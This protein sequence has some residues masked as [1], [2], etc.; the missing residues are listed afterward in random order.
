MKVI[1]VREKMLQA[2]QTAASVAPTRSPKPILQNVKLEATKDGGTL[3]ATDLEI[4]IRV[5]VADLE[6]T[7]PGE[8]VLPV[9]RV[10]AILRESSDEKLHIETDSSGVIIR[11]D[12]SEFKLPAENP[13]EFPTVAAFAE[14]KYHELPA[15][16]LKEII[17]RT[18]FATDN[19]STRY[20]LGGV[21][22]ELSKDA[23]VAVA[24]DGRRLAKMEA[25]A[26]AVGGH[27]T[28]DAMTIVPTRA[29]QLID[30]ALTEGDAEVQLSARGNDVLVKS[31]RA[32]IFARL[33]EGRFPRW[34]DVF[35]K[36]T[37]GQTIALNVGTFH[38]A[39]RQ[40]AIATSEESRGVTFT[41][42][43]GQAE[44]SGRAADVGQARVT[45]PIDYSGNSIAIALDPRFVS[46]FLKTLDPATTVQLDVRDGDSAAVLRTED[47]YGYVIM[48]LAR[49]R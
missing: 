29:M 4:G 47:G 1:C 8:V 36:R 49:D 20:A 44:L 18:V 37:D 45:V 43:D 3:L 30:R 23:V 11:G 35:P 24:T 26:N 48:P 14:H 17:R 12:R 31:P 2:F 25:T 28:A 41:F 9:T 6:V 16:M 5:Q 21:L 42:K 7:Q 34:R 15:R 19:E 39:V 38:N 46:D 33:L 13:N 27:E 10:G 40:A 22:L 32:T